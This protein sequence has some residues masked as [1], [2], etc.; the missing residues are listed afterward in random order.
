[1]RMAQLPTTRNTRTTL[2]Q[3]PQARLRTSTRHRKPTWLR[4]STQARED[5]VGQGHSGRD[6]TNLQQMWKTNH[7]QRRLGPRPHRQP[8][9]MDRTRTPQLQQT[10]RPSQE[11]RKPRTLETLT[12]RNSNNNKTKNKTIT[13][14]LRKPEKIQS[15]T[16]PDT[17]RGKPQT[18]KTRT[19]GEGTRKF[20]DSSDFYRQGINRKSSDWR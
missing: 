5:T 12:K 1:M 15:Q 4:Q 9:S 20:A 19:A 11:H 2:L 8:P 7:K 18:A 10:R 3:S 6:H 17:P 14:H 13:N 16:K